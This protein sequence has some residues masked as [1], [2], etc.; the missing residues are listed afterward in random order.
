MICR[1]KN[2]THLLA[3]DTPAVR[4]DDDEALAG[5]VQAGALDL[6]DVASVLVGGDDLLNFGG[7]D[8]ETSAGRPDAVALA[9]EDGGLVDVAGANEA[10][11]EGVLVKDRGGDRFGRRGRV[12]TW[13]QRM[14]RMAVVSWVILLCLRR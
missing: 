5:D 4:L 12:C 8:G 9:V 14:L 7:R 6:L 2:S 13:C 1:R 11:G 3:V 10:I